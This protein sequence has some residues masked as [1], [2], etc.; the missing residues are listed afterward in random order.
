MSYTDVQ[1]EIQKCKTR[2]KNLR[3]LEGIFRDGKVVD[4]IGKRGDTSLHVACYAGVVSV[5]RDLIAMGANVN[6]INE[7]GDTPFHMANM[8]QSY[9]CMSLLLRAGMDLNLKDNNGETYMEIA[10]REQDY[11]VVKKLV[12]HGYDLNT[13]LSRG[14]YLLNCAICYTDHNG[15][16]AVQHL[17]S[18]GADIN[19]PDAEGNT[20]LH[21][22]VIKNLPE[23]VKI[24]TKA[25]A[26]VN[27]VNSKNMTPL[28]ISAEFSRLTIMKTLLK[29]PSISIDF[30]GGSYGEKTALSYAILKY[31][32]FWPKNAMHR[33]IAAGA[34][35]LRTDFF[36]GENHY[37]ELAF[38]YHM[39]E[40]IHRLF[41]LGVTLKTARHLY[42]M[43]RLDDYRMYMII[44]AYQ[45]TI[46][47]QD[48]DTSISI[49][50]SKPLLMRM[51]Q[52][53]QKLI[54]HNQ[55]L[56]LMETCQYHLKFAKIRKDFSKTKFA[57]GIKKKK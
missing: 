48:P 34:E 31:N 55:R 7:I 49:R 25:G 45:K 24:L 16:N 14:S 28:M 41:H 9:K 5:V 19:S 42:S 51:K 17:I 27:R 30:Q 44:L 36:D 3:E 39:D 26:L 50:Y 15:L 4:I 46:E 29:V 11:V 22:A 52:V 38:M 33:L 8:N 47:T 6:A 37:M 43:A 18:H 1:W 54:N 35:Y 32:T 10:L 57:Q 2:L 40:A 21:L 56:T 20:P 53:P 13:K 12:K 23:V